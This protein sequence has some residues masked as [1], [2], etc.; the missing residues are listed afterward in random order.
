M[1]WNGRPAWAQVIN[2]SD[3][4]GLW[5][6]NGRLN[7]RKKPRMDSRL[8]IGEIGID[9]AGRQQRERNEIPPQHFSEAWRGSF[10]AHESI[11]S[12]AV[13]LAV[14]EMK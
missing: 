13:T 8:N 10:Q 4:P 3:S 14:I 2:A 9:G 7:F 5:I 6:R 12:S 1:P 11:S